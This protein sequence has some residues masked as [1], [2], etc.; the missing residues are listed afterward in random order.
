MNQMSAVRGI[1]TDEDSIMA[2]FTDLALE[3]RL[4]E[5][6]WDF[7]REHDEVIVKGRPRTTADLAACL[8]WARFLGMSPVYTDVSGNCDC[9]LGVNGPWVLEIFAEVR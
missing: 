8:S 3:L 9:W 7:L 2:T 4:P 5:L 6:E 1:E